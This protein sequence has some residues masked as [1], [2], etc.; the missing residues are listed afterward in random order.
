MCAKAGVVELGPFRNC[1]VFNQ[2]GVRVH[3]EGVV[4][5][6]AGQGAGVRF[7][8]RNFVAC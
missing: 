7:P 3:V 8:N 2:S 6:E 4:E 5:D 1:R